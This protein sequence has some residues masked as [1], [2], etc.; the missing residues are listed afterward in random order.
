MTRYYLVIDRLGELGNL[1]F[2]RGMIGVINDPAPIPVV[3]LDFMPDGSPV[4]FKVEAE[5]DTKKPARGPARSQR[6]KD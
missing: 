3:D 6:R 1:G 5:L 4:K 2:G